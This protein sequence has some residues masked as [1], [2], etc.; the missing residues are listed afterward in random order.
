MSKGSERRPHVEGRPVNRVSSAVWPVSVRKVVATGKAAQRR[1]DWIIQGRWWMV[2]TDRPVLRVLFLVSILLVVATSL[3]VAVLGF[4]FWYLL[5]L[6]ALFFVGLLLIP[7]FL[8]NREG[9][10]GL[11][12]TSLTFAQEMR[13]SAGILSAQELRNLPGLFPLR[14]QPDLLS[15]VAPSTPMPVDPPLVR[16]LE[17]YDLRST[18]VEHFLAGWPGEE[19]GEHALVHAADNNLW[20]HHNLEA[21]DAEPLI[22]KYLVDQIWEEDKL[23]LKDFPKSEQ[24]Q[25]SDL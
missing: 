4:P 2:P 5:L 8:G 19:T 17:T 14:D 23:S 10:E 24:G 20:P 15:D 25:P 6:P 12:S 7:A 9:S 22:H 16:V 3:L 11:R 21:Q 1:R 13:S 18:P